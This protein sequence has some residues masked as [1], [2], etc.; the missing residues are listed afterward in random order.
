MTLPTPEK[1]RSGS[2]SNCKRQHEECQYSPLQPWNQRDM[3]EGLSQKST[4]RET[5]TLPPVFSTFCL[6]KPCKA[7]ASEIGCVAWQ[8]LREQSLQAWSLIRGCSERCPLC[9]SKCDLVQ[10]SD[11]HHS[12]T[13]FF[14][15]FCMLELLFASC[16]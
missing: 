5:L 6:I 12:S 10:V 7:I 4:N 2:P 11:I 16:C 8:A 13:S 1:Y 3:F 9:G 15:L 14:C